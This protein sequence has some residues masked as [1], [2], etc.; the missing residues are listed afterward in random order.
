MHVF[1]TKLFRIVRGGWLTVGLLAAVGTVTVAVNGADAQ[2]IVEGARQGARTGDRVGGPVGGVV[3]GAVGAGVGGATGAV[4]G[5][6]GLPN[7]S[8]A[9]PYRGR[10]YDRRR[11]RNRGSRRT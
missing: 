5:V 3:G 10:R 6:L 7:R 11:Y 9:R 8:Y 1:K 2:G 4:N